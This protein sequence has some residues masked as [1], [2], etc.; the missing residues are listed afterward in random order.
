MAICEFDIQNFEYNIESN[1]RAM[2]LPV[3][4]DVFNA[5]AGIATGLKAIDSALAFKASD[6]P[7]SA[8]AKGGRL[9]T[10]YG[11]VYASWWAGAVIGSALMASKR[12]TRCSVSEL[13]KAVAAFGM[14]TWWVDDAVR[15]HPEI[16]RVN[17]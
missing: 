16:L 6:V 17:W 2:Y 9:A 5:A 8:I 10:T 15:D 14:S 1:L 3:P 11:G 7:L 13:K 12:A 4:N